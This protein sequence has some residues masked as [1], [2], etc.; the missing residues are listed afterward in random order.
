MTTNKCRVIAIFTPKPEF[1]SEVKDLLTVITPEVHKEP[2]CELYQLH[3][4]V[5]GQLVFVETWT[6]REDWVFHGT[7]DPVARIQ[8]GIAGK[9][10]TD[11]VVIEM[12][13][14]DAV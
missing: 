4:S 12:Y 14:T 10:E 6:T 1:F 11:V 7:Q 13:E 8:A 5:D 2:G 3:E 9:L